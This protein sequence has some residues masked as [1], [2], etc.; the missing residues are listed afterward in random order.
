MSRDYCERCLVERSNSCG[1]I[2]EK[3]EG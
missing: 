2:F 1:C 3:E